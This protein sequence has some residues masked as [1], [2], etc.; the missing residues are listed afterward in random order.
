MADQ[1]KWKNLASDASIITRDTLKKMI[2]IPEDIVNYLA[3]E[4]GVVPVVYGR[5]NPIEYTMQLGDTML[6]E[7]IE[8]HPE[9]ANLK[10]VNYAFTFNRTI[11]YAA[12]KK[13]EKKEDGTEEKKIN[14]YYLGFIDHD[15]FN[16][17]YINDGIGVVRNVE[18]HDTIVNNMLNGIH[19]ADDEHPANWR[20]MIPNKENLNEDTINSI[21]ELWWYLILKD[22]R[23]EIKLDPVWNDVY[24][25]AGFAN[26]Y[27]WCNRNGFKKD[28]IF[29]H[30]PDGVVGPNT[31]AITEKEADEQTDKPEPESN[32]Q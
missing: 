11:V 30:T 10:E 17:F 21:K 1:E 13:M 20:D 26:F 2:G 25:G 22:R 28:C 5:R 16:I 8:N 24:S 19:F 6:R 12:E 29:H 31:C 18:A 4:D 27:H 14:L 9:H 23:K 7:F 15:I 32:T 3:P